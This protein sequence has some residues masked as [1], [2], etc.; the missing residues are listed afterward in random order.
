MVC[1]NNCGDITVYHQLYF[2]YLAGLYTH[3]FI[4]YSPFS[5][6]FCHSYILTT[7]NSILK[8][9]KKMR[10]VGATKVQ[11]VRVK[12]NTIVTCGTMLIFLF[13]FKPI[14]LSNNTQKPPKCC[15][16]MMYI[17]ETVNHKCVIW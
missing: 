10:D 1:L 8:G 6:H 14:C 11:Q 15:F 9:H 4:L 3:T 5:V 13:F 16:N 12:S 2:I 17:E 7:G